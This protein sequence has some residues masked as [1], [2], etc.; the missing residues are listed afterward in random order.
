MIGSRTPSISKGNYIHV[1][2][3]VSLYIHIYT[4]LHVLSLVSLILY[5][6]YLNSKQPLL[7]MIGNRTP[8]II[9]EH[10]DLNV[11]ENIED[12]DVY[13]E[14][15]CRGY[16]NDL[17][18]ADN[19]SGCF[20]NIFDVKNDDSGVNNEGDSNK[21]INIEENH[22]KIHE[23]D[24]DKN[25]DD[26]ERIPSQYNSISDDD[27]DYCIRTPISSSHNLTS[28]S[29]PNNHTPSTSTIGTPNNRT[30]KSSDIIC[31]SPNQ[32]PQYLNYFIFQTLIEKTKIERK[33]YTNSEKTKSIKKNLRIE[34][35][36]LARRRSSKRKEK[37]L[38]V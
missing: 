19:H 29:P 18:Y 7:G 16:K 11:I 9:N 21:N 1:Y 13:L 37:L 6:I 26:I 30:P 31:T 3:Y 33:N 36:N 22:K 28:I 24:N 23:N 38:Q 34:N 25:D 14:K 20:N 35:E 5:I 17:P 12:D 10:H 27:D 2:K 32:E 4:Y 15:L 8:S